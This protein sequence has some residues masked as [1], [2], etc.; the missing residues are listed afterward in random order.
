MVDE[1]PIPQILRLENALPTLRKLRET[2]N[3]ATEL[4]STWC[5]V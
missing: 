4:V 5:E 3:E 1:V 2:L